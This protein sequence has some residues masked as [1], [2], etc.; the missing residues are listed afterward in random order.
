MITPWCVFCPVDQSLGLASQIAIEVAGLK[1]HC[2]LLAVLLEL[3]L[4]AG[5]GAGDD[6]SDYSHDVVDVVSWLRCNGR[7]RRYDQAALLAKLTGI[8][9]KSVLHL[10]IMVFS[11]T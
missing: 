7:R 5:L 10:P 2:D 8:T 3:D 1:P 9:S 11:T 4:I 6:C